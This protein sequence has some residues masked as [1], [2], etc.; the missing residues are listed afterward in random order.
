MSRR[1]KNNDWSV[2]TNSN[3]TIAVEHAQLSVLQDI[4]DELQKLNATLACPNFQS[5][6]RYIRESTNHLNKIDKRLK[7][8]IPL[9]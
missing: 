8:R 1:Y 4:R 3:G 9:R 2:V 5:L 7:K 6:P